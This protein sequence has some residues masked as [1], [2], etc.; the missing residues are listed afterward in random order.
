MKRTTYRKESRRDFREWLDS[1]RKL[2]SGL[3]LCEIAEAYGRKLPKQTVHTT[4]HAMGIQYRKTAWSNAS[5]LNQ[6]TWM[7]N[8]TITEDGCWEWKRARTRCNYGQLADSTRA[9]RFAYELFVGPIPPG[10]CVLHR[11]DNPPC[12][13]P[14]HLF[15]GTNGDNVHDSVAKGRFTGRKLNAEKA[16]AIREALA[17]GQS[18]FDLAKQ[19]GVV[20]SS[21]L[22]IAWNKTYKQPAAYPLRQAI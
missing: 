16:R 7:R 1:N 19:Y 18:H 11:C 22:L 15:L 5:D 6:T 20:P 14:A 4:V 17:A 13:N 9:H 10:M 21:I 2:V 3:R 12:T 8:V